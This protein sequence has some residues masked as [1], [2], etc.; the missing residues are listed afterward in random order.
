[1]HANASLAESLASLPEPERNQ[2]LADFTDAECAELLYDWAVWARPNQIEPAGVWLLWLILAGRGYGKTRM[3][4]EWVRE[5]VKTTE[6]VNLI[7]KD[8]AD[9]RSVMI[10]GESGILAVCPPWERPEALWSQ[11][12]LRWPNGAISE[13][14]SA[15][16]PEGVRGL[17]HGALW[18]DELAAWQYVDDT[19]D[20]AMLGLRLGDDPRA[21][22]T[23]TPKPIP[24]LREL[25]GADNVH[26][27]KGTT[28]ENRPNLPATFYS[29]VITKYEGTR[30]GRQELEA[31]LLLDEGLAYRVIQGTHVIPPFVLPKWWDRFEAMDYGST[32]PT[33][34]GAFAV[35]DDQNVVVFDMYYAPGLIAEHAQ[36]VL[37]RRRRWG[38]RVCFAPPDIKHKF[39]KLALNGTEMSVET[40]FM[41]HGISFLPAQN[42]R[43][44]GYQRVSE[45]LRCVPDRRFPDWHP[46]AGEPGAPRLFV[47][48]TESM[49]PLVQQ[50]RDA[51]LESP[52]SP[53][54]RFPGEAVDKEW[55]SPHGHA[56]A[57]LRYGLMSRPGASV[58]GVQ[59]PDDPRAALLWAVERKRMN[60]VS[61]KAD[62]E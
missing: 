56:H 33:A 17:Q 40:E 43:R 2:L 46:R 60:P 21:L 30:L 55:E 41:E 9:L 23:T 11:R 12:K 18:M 16:D 54:S 50:L 45:M 5:K 49:A 1:M 51:P 47:L 62:Y 22:V 19:Y 36:E 14:R 24:L 59:P 44:A 28:Y 15:E 29:Q 7:G 34:W 37:K 38:S 27:T 13:W 6:R 35:D 48:D 20:M 26:V 42:D 3:G 57:M 52:D 8:A 31:E 61:R 32:N 10:E 53:L 39:G 25:V 58:R 4:A